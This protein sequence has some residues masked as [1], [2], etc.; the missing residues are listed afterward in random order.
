MSA[1]TPH[2]SSGAGWQRGERMRSLMRTAERVERGV[3]LFLVADFPVI[4]V[5][6]FALAVVAQDDRVFFRLEGIDDG[7]ERFVLD[8]DQLGAVVGDLARRRDDAGDFLILVERLAERQHHLLVVTVEGR[9]PLELG[10]IEISPVITALT[11]GNAIA[12]LL[13]ML[14]MRACGYGLCTS[15]R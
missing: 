8:F 13:S 10:G 11:P 14:L 1:T 7:I 2:G 12:L 9:Q 5:I 4:D 3:G 15:A 6:G